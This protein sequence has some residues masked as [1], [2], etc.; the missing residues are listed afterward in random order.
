[1]ENK[2]KGGKVNFRRSFFNPVQIILA[3]NPGKHHDV[4]SV[5]ERS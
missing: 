3:I 4:V 5:K 2:D 1:V